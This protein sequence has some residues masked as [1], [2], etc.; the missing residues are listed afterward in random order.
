MGVVDGQ[1]RCTVTLLSSWN[2]V[3]TRYVLSTHVNSS[4]GGNVVVAPLHWLSVL[5][6]ATRKPPFVGG[7]V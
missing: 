1:P 3:S 2:V 7:T 6:S 5:P 4:V